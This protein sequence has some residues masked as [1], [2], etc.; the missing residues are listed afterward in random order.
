MQSFNHRFGSWD[1]EV[2]TLAF[3]RKAKVAHDQPSTIIGTVKVKAY[4]EDSKL[5]LLASMRLFCVNV[6]LEFFYN[7]LIL[8]LL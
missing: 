2:Q 8:L 3:R 7:N 5:R 6:L 4:G 1:N